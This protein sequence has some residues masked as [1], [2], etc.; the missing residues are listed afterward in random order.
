MPTIR[1]VA[2]SAGVSI[3]TVSRVL[4]KHKAVRKETVE[5][6]NRAI[7]A[8]DYMPDLMA[9]AMRGGR[10]GAIGLVGDD[11]AL[12]P[13]AVEILRGVQDACASEDRM[14]LMSNTKGDPAL[15]EHA[16]RA[17]IARKVEGII[18]ATRYLRILHE[19][20]PV[21]GVPAVLVNCIAPTGDVPHILPDDAGGS[22]TATAYLVRLGHRKIALV[23]INPAIMAAERREGGFRRAMHE[24]GLTVPGGR[25]QPGQ[26]FGAAGEI[27]TT[28]QAVAAILEHEP[29]VTAILCGTD[30]I[31]MRV[32]NALRVRGAIVPRDISVVGFDDFTM[33]TQGLDPPLTSVALPYYDMGQAAV[34]RLRA[35]ETN[36]VA[37]GISL[38]CPL[39]IRQSCQ[40]PRTRELLTG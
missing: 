30:A 6:V 10:S 24:D 28:D 37:T 7:A 17:L 4:N 20:P 33:I 38:S 19:L 40:A 34:A 11:V 26:H 31:A 3:K 36:D 21:A 15:T 29:D 1:N 39:V 14:L 5:R 25:V 12:T 2:Q 9:R 27:F 13:Y 32:C 22:H 8:L 35:G 23:S 18:F 16:V